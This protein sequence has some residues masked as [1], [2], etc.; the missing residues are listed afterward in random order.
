MRKAHDMITKRSPRK[1][2]VKVAVALVRTRSHIL[3][4]VFAATRKEGAQG[5]RML[6]S[7]RGVM[8]SMKSIDVH[9]G[10]KSS[11]GVCFAK[12]SRIY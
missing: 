3:V 7:L 6:F 4:L 1:R 11:V 5:P 12:R 9:I 2:K 10:H 8:I